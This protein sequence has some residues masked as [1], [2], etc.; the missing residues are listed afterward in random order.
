MLLILVFVQHLFIYL[1]KAPYKCINISNILYI[2]EVLSKN[3]C[4]FYSRVRYILSARCLIYKPSDCLNQEKAVTEALRRQSRKAEKL[5]NNSLSSLNHHS[6]TKITKS[7][8]IKY[9]AKETKKP[10]DFIRMEIKNF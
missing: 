7:I 3:L 5:L 4:K 9:A 1:Q 8:C 2:V 10:L 6:Q